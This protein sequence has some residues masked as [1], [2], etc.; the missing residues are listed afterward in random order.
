MYIRKEVLSDVLKRI[1]KLLRPQGALYVSFKYGTNESVK[2]GRY[3]N[4]LTGDE[5]RTALEDAGLLVKELFLSTDVR[6]GHGDET[7]VNAIAVKHL[8]I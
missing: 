3:Y 2:E 5:C 6:I 1:Y 8:I 7:W 4:N